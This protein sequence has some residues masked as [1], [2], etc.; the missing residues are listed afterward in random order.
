MQDREK[1]ISPYHLKAVDPDTA[2]SNVTFLIEKPP[3]YGQLYVRG[4][5]IASSFSQRDV[6]LGY[7]HYKSDGTQAG[8]DNFLFS[9]SDGNHKGFLINGTIQRH[10]AMANI[11]IKPT[12]EGRNN[13][14]FNLLRYSSECIKIF[15]MLI[16]LN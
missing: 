8:L 12:L 9:L 10:P 6:E 3:T 2:A 13:N 1:V 5:R 7:V 14:L 15:S 11:Y 4:G 16:Y